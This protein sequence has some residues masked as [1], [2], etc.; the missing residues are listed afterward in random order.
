MNTKELRI[1]NYVNWLNKNTFVRAIQYCDDST[2][3][4]STDISGAITI[5]QI[6]PISLTEE[7]LQKFKFMESGEYWDYYPCISLTKLKDGLYF[8]YNEYDPNLSIKVEYVHQLQNLFFA[9]TGNELT[10]KQ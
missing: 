6:K 9:L 8:F 10:L 7:W 2:S 4:V 1:G 5:N 3:Y